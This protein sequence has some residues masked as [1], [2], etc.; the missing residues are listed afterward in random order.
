MIEVDPQVVLLSV[1]TQ[2]SSVTAAPVR[3]IL[4]LMSAQPAQIQVQPQS[5]TV[6]VTSP[7]PQGVPGPAGPVGPAG[8]T[9]YHRHD[10]TDAAATWIVDH[11][12]GAVPNT[13]ISIANEVV[14]TTI[15]HVTVNRTSIEFPDPT[16]GVAIFS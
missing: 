8:P 10:Q 7:G 5:V 1:V 14:Y 15:T 12:L 4:N 9:F 3:P 6:A 13:T 16:I 11:N 2:S